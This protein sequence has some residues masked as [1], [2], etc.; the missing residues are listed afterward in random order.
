MLCAD[1]QSFFDDRMERC[2]P[3]ANETAYVILVLAG[4]VLLVIS[5]VLMSRYHVLDRFG[6][7]ALWHRLDIAARQVSLTTKLKVSISY[8]QIVTQLNRVY[9]IVYPPAYAQ[10]IKVLDSIFHVFFGWIPGVAT[11]CTGLGLAHE[12]LLLC[13]VPLIIVLGAFCVAKARGKPLLSALPFA[14]VTTF[15]CFPFVSS[16]GFRALAPCDCFDYVDGGAACFLHDAYLVRCERQSSGAY[17][18][19][20]GIQMAAWLSI[21]I[22]ACVVPLFYA[23]LLYICRR[24]LRGDA[25]P[26]TLSRALQFLTKDYQAHAFFWGA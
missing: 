21:G 26:T 2:K 11:A 24:P 19:S 16:R 5:L 8:Y 7:T 4:I 23:S 10:V 12:L 6:C 18:P 25:P 3:C 14:L 20:A 13:L 22:Y 9:A 17:K 15:L 1:A